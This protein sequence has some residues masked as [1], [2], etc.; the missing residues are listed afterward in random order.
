MIGS[1]L[2][3]RKPWAVLVGAKNG[4]QIWDPF[5]PPPTQASA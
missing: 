2:V 3:L 5:Y 1:V 4:S